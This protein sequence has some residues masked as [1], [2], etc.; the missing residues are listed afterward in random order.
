MIK[1]DTKVA[2]MAVAMVTTENPVANNK[3]L[4]NCK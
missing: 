3:M 2:L 4:H 1:M